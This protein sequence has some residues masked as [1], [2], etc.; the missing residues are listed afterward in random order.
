M[1]ATNI[2]AV[3]TGL[4]QY[5]VLSPGERP[6]GNAPRGTASSRRPKSSDRTGLRLSEIFNRNGGGGS[7][8]K[9]NKIKA[10]VGCRRRADEG[11]AQGSLVSSGGR[12]GMSSRGRSHS[13][14][15]R[16]VTDAHTSAS[17]N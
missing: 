1:V 14:P 11:R 2:A 4:D 6:L 15:T 8:G 10:R 16:A 12:E 7:G 3:R 17:N 9:P 5:Q 13:I